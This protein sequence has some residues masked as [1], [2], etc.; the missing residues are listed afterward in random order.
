MTYKA[1]VFTLASRTSLPRAR[2]MLVFWRLATSACSVDLSLTA[3]CVVERERE[4]GKWITSVSCTERRGRGEGEEGCSYCNIHLLLLQHTPLPTCQCVRMCILVHNL[5]TITTQVNSFVEN[6]TTHA[7]TS[8]QQ[9]FLFQ[10]LHAPICN[11]VTL[12]EILPTINRLIP[13]VL[14]D[15]EEPS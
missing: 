6:R 4:E 3:A 12:L 9:Y 1:Y 7:C 13:T 5:C 11:R 10:V 8:T 2:F 15:T 14:V